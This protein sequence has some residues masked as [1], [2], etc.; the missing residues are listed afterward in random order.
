MTMIIGRLVIDLK[1]TDLS[2]ITQ[3]I[4]RRKHFSSSLWPYEFKWCRKYKCI[5]H[6]TTNTVRTIA[7]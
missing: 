6:H 3:E 2:R 5:T 4:F 7:L 1:F